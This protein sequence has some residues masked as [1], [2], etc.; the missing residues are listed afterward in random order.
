MAADVKFGECLNSLLSILGVSMSQLSKAINV[1]SSLVNRW[2]NGKRV[3]P[4]SSKYIENITEYLS[5]NIKNSFQEQHINELF[6]SICSDNKLIDSTQ[7]KIKMIL[8]ESQG[9]SIEYIKKERFPK[10]SN[11]DQPYSKRHDNICKKSL[12]KNT[13][14]LT[15]FM[16]FSSEDKIILGLENILSAGVFLLEFAASQKGKKNSTIYMSYHNNLDMENHHSDYLVRCKDALIKAINNG[17]NIV[18][19]LRLDNN[20][21]K[22]IGFMNFLKPL[23]VTGK[24]TLYHINKYD[25]SVTNN[26]NLIVSGI[27]A[28]SCFLVKLN[29]KASSA[30]YFR[31]KT[32]VDILEN[33]INIFLSTC[34]SP[35]IK[36]YS[37]KNKMDYSYCLAKSEEYIGNRFLFKYCFGALTIPISL[38]EKLLKNK[39][40]SIDKILTALELHKRRL[41]AFIKNVQIYE[42]NDI[43]SIDCVNNLINHRQLYLY[44][45]TENELVNLEVQDIIDL[46]HNIITLLE[47]YNNYN[48][49]LISEDTDSTVKDSDFY[50]I[51]KERQAVLLETLTASKSIP[52]V[53]LSIKEPMMVK[54][55]EEY[56][57][58]LWRNI[59]P[60]NKAKTE[61]IAWIRRQIELLYRTF[62]D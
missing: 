61:V 33:H 29:S 25:I 41:N 54:A 55:F 60:V 37:H 32:A 51:V 3:P 50:F 45:Y 11:N 39:G 27:G 13:N 20:I 40:L 26:D 44:D 14:K 17:W 7:E 46:L 15:S 34:S 6:L 56:F 38:Y 23:M 28:L 22:T 30:F 43:Y 21:A 48:I 10:Y 42:Y 4:Y 47:T 24:I 2:V 5:K 1:D 9:Y 12:T 31:N 59:A 19:L 16:D 52:Q 18:L 35:T 53:Q 36:Y 49:A 57:K 8:F 62:T 58:E